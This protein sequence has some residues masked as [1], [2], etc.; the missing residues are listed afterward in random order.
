M[1]S[2]TI[3]A[4]FSSEIETVWNIVTNNKE[5][6]WRSDLEKI[7]ISDDEKSF[8]EYTRDGFETK[9]IIINKIPFKQYEFKMENKKF[10][11]HWSGLFGKNASGGTKIVFTE[12]IRMK[13]PILKL[14]SYFFL[15]LKKM[16]ETYIA[17]LKK[18]LKET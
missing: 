13:N 10:T 17:D 8:I 11:G 6:H 18:R 5:Y 4:E 14:L 2:S 16:Q 3:T 9:F 7:E 1:K 12:N 15:N